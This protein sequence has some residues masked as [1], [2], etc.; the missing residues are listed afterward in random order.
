MPTLELRR[1]GGLL[2]QLLL[3]YEA[4]VQHVGDARV[5]VDVRLLAKAAAAR[6]LAPRRHVEMDVDL[7]TLDV[8][9][10]GG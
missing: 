10:S 4:R 1:G 7:T 2:A 3:Q 8:A 9:S 5:M 6:C